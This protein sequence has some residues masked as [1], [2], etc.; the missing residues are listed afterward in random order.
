M[1][2][3]LFGDQ[4][5]RKQNL[6]GYLLNHIVLLSICKCS[7]DR[8]PV[9]S[10]ATVDISLNPFGSY[11]WTLSDARNTVILVG[12]KLAYPVPV[13]CR[14]VELHV[15][16]HMDDDCLYVSIRDREGKKVAGRGPYLHRPSQQ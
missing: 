7:F 2:P 4:Y 6:K 13:N 15:V 11:N 14:A 5:Q 10:S 3:G 12:V 1:V 8:V 9:E 16:C